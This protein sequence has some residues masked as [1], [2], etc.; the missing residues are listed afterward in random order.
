MDPRLDYLYGQTVEALSAGEEAWDW[1][2]VLS[3]GSR[4]SNS[5]KRR[6]S[7]PGI[8]IGYT[9]TVAE[10]DAD[11]TDVT[12][13]FVMSRGEGVEPDV[14]EVTMTKTQL[15]INDPVISN[16]THYPWVKVSDDPI[17]SEPENA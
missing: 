3:S 8:I 12:L 4:I 1:A 14:Q 11:S 15:G 5:D 10:E 16:E 13:R 6:T 2:I 9:F 17:P 7:L